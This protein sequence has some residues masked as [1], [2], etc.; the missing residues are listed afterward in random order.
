MHK[1]S[2]PSASHCLHG[3]LSVLLAIC[4][5]SVEAG[6]P[7]ALR[8]HDLQGASHASPYAG[9]VVTN[10]PGIVTQRLTN[11]FYF[12]DPFPDSNDAT[13]EG[14]WVFTGSAPTVSVGDQ[15]QVSGTVLEFTPAGNASNLAFT[16][17]S[18]PSVTIVSTGNPLPTA[19]L[20]GAGG[21]IPPTT[22][23]YSGPAI[24]LNTQ[25]HTLSTV[26]NG[27]DFYESLEGMRVLINNALVVGPTNALGETPVVA[28]LG[29]GASLLSGRGGIVARSGDFNPERIIVREAA[30]GTLY[31]VGTRFPSVT[32]VITYASG[33]YVLLRDPFFPLVPDTSQVPA[34]QV[35]ALVGSPT[36]ATIATMSMRNLEPGDA[37]HFAALAAEI[38]NNL[39][40]PDII[41][42][43]DI[44]D[45]NGPFDNTVVDATTTMSMLI[46][47]IVDAG[48]PTYDYRS[49]DPLQDQD[50]GPFG[51]NARTVVMFNAARVLAVDRPG[52]TATS[53]TT[54]TLSGGVARLSASPGRIDPTNSAWNNMPKPLALELRFGEKTL[55]V[56]AAAFR[57]KSGDDALFGRYQ[58]PA[59]PSNAL[60]TQQAAIVQSFVASILAIHAASRVVVLGNFNDTEF[61]PALAML[62]GTN[63][64]N[65]TRL[66]PESSRYTA[67]VEGNGVALDHIL[68][69]RALF[70]EQDIDIVHA[71]S[72]YVVAPTP[73]DPVLA[74]LQFFPSCVLDV[75]GDG[76][77]DP[78]TDGLI[79]LRAMLGLDGTAIANGTLLGSAPRNTWAQIEP[80]VHIA[81][82]DVDGNNVVDPRFDGMLLL[83]AMFGFR[84]TAVTD[85]AVFPGAPRQDW[86]AV[87]TFLNANCGTAYGP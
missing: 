53:T 19:T 28:D 2:F 3:V 44:E 72:E 47:A 7:P 27:I 29:A 40:S 16:E 38:V 75:D 50:G 57:D 80:Y 32:G 48:G 56:I 85:N 6:I 59:A 83:R 79:L 8:I 67:N 35:T 62:E 60:R 33:N 26:D 39:K 77:I 68:V 49:I 30:G 15:V 82:L 66:V 31:D 54:V 71:N 18:G 45:S 74:R 52:G 70:G 37:P 36:Q 81:A 76:K 5:P 73:R 17:I 63:L 86:E 58:P 21:R 42:A 78:L 22:T 65:L 1:H 9:Q 61:S 55:F 46:A 24:D 20:I 34:K 51:G 64:H 43:F 12:Q 69:S 41:A 14:L 25:A 23:I 84:G 4:A 13:S 87:R 10:I 11:G